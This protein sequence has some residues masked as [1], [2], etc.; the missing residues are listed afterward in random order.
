MLTCNVLIMYSGLPVIGLVN[1]ITSSEMI[2]SHSPIAFSFS[3]SLTL[4]LNLL[5]ISNERKQLTSI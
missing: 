1:I 2:K 3:E 4:T 5:W